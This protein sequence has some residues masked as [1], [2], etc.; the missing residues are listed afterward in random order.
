MNE[1]ILARY[2]QRVKELRAE[3]ASGQEQVRALEVRRTQ[4]QETMM[5]ISGAIQVLEELIVE[6]RKEP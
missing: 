4:L 3:L 6:E 2:E 5:R 1:V